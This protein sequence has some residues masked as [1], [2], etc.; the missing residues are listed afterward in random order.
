MK[1]RSYAN[2]GIFALVLFDMLINL[3]C[4]NQINK[5][6]QTKKNSIST[7]ASHQMFFSGKMSFT[8]FFPSSL[9]LC[10]LDRMNVS[11]SNKKVW[12][13]NTKCLP[14]QER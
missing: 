6:K 2:S 14:N 3:Y 7:W 12:K 4:P 8:V 10:Q 1:F 9:W 11:V 5:N 13:Q